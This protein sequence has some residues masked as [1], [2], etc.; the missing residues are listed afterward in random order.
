[1]LGY[2]LRVVDV[3]HDLPSHLS[4]LPPLSCC[5][6]ELRILVDNLVKFIIFYSYMEG[7][8]MYL[9]LSEL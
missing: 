8:R 7:R 6:L 4:A 2:F 5:E 9:F 1:M 3:T